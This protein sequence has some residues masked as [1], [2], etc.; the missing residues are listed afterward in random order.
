MRPTKWPGTVLK[1]SK[2]SMKETKTI[3]LKNRPKGRPEMADFKFDT[4]SVQDPG[5]GEVLVKALYVSVDPY[6]RGRMNDSP[7]Y[8]PP[9]ELNKPITSIIIAEVIESKHDEFK[10]GDHVSGMMAWK[11]QQVIKANG[12]IKVDKD[13]AQLSAYLGILGMTGL[14]AYLGLTEIGRPKKGET[15]LVS[16]AAG[17]V[18]STV[19]Q[20][21]K[22]MGLKV[23]GIAGTDEKVEMIKNDFGFD[24]GINY[25]TA[26]N[27]T[28]DI[29][30]TCPDGVD[31]YF[32]NVGGEISEAVLFNIN[33]FSRTVVCG[34]I[35]VYN[36]TSL[37][38]STSVQ[39]FLIKKSSLMQ[40]FVISDFAD[41]HAEGV[42]KLAEWLKEGKLTYTETVKEGF[43]NIPQ[44]F[45][46]LFDGKN[47]GKMVVKV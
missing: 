43:K 26:E 15:L 14:T 6:L 40:G 23:V 9:F 17:A 12:L 2:E 10:K 3:L 38:Q 36:E 29:K 21:G 42:Q 41:K 47:K 19:G 35:S 11:E 1:N 24:K 31:I 46:D 34:A 7:S 30:K 13:K 16:G 8:I 37:P 20:I 18:G 39:P 45:L 44:A 28:E 27:M 5:D 25:N 4:E 22:I 33:K 32:D